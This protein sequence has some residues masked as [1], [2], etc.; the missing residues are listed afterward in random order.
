MR[1]LVK[2]ES[3]ACIFY[4]KLY[5]TPPRLFAMAEFSQ[6]ITIILAL[7][8]IQSPSVLNDGRILHRNLRAAASV[9]AILFPD[10]KLVLT[11]QPFQQNGARP[12]IISLRRAGRTTGRLPVI[13]SISQIADSSRMRNTWPPHNL[14]GGI[15]RA[16]LIRPIKYSSAGTRYTAFVVN[17]N[18]GL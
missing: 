13:R 3:Q 1:F 18:L 12:C 4:I 10:G 7:T 14:V 8:A 16:T 2:D 9:P 15:Y 17:G 6:R 5:T 11:R